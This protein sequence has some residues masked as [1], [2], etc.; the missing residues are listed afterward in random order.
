MSQ[1]RSINGIT[2][3]SKA[4]LVYWGGTE[5]QHAPADA[6]GYQPLDADLTTIASL[7]PAAGAVMIGDGSA[8]TADTTPTLTGLLTTNGQV[9]F[10]A[11][12]NPS[13][14]ANTLD[15]YEEGAWTPVASSSGGTITSY[16]SDGTYTK[17]GRMVIADLNVAISNAGT[18]TG[19]LFATLPFTAAAQAV[20][21]G[22]EHFATGIM[23][24]GIVSAASASL[25]IVR[26]D[27]TTIIATGR[28]VGMTIAYRV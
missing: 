4:R 12:Q 24:Q 3:P 23:V 28:T 20:A 10:P 5:Y 9:A 16:L 27:N 1:P 25:S 22:R 8:W 13:S 18:A 2:D 6:V 15:D 26:Y 19:T 7:T 21:F 17:I 14:D 11:T